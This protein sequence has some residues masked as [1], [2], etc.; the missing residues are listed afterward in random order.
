MRSQAYADPRE[1]WKSIFGLIA[2][3][4]S[5]RAQQKNGLSIARG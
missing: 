5:K 1:A 4:R 3:R 2:A